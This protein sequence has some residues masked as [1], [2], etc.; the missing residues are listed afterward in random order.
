VTSGRTD[1]AHDPVSPELVLVSTAEDARRQRDALP[2]HPWEPEAR[3]SNTDAARPTPPPYPRV[4]ADDAAAPRRGG[5]RRRRLALAAGFV[6]AAAVAAGGYVAATRGHGR[7][8]AAAV[9][10]VQAPR[11][12][13]ASS[14]VSGSTVAHE[15]QTRRTKTRQ[16]T[17]RTTTRAAAAPPAARRRRTTAV[18]PKRAAGAKP[19]TAKSHAGFVPSRTWSWAPR[20]GAARYRVTFFLNGHAVFDGRPASARLVLPRG[21]RFRAGVYRWVVRALPA[22]AAAKPVVDATFT[23]SR[24]AAAAANGR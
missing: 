1:D 12:T 3:V 4:T 7:T 18:K 22:S 13:A 10:P 5:S 19:A 17:A 8:T 9:V 11:G 23:V 21:F 20:A 6:L 14:T 24:A 16:A 2:E 15:R